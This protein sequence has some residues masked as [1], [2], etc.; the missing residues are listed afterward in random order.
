VVEKQT[1][2]N[3]IY[4]GQLPENIEESDIKKLFPKSSKIDLITAKTTAKGVRPGFAFVAFSDDKLAAAA[5]KLGPSLTLKNSQL[6]VAYQTKRATPP[7]AA[8]ATET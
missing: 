2:T 1:V 6:K 8:A 5:I 4:V 3:T 7:A